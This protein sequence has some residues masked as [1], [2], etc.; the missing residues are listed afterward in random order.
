MRTFW[1]EQESP[2]W[3]VEQLSGFPEL[4]IP[5]YYDRCGEINREIFLKDKTSLPMEI[6]GAEDQGSLMV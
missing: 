1:V 4:E 6:E 3:P 5:F 2:A